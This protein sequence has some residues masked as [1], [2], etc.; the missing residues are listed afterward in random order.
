MQA[1]ALRARGKASMSIAVWLQP[2]PGL[3]CPLHKAAT[4]LAYKVVVARALRWIQ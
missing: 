1:S 2:K 3:E 4:T